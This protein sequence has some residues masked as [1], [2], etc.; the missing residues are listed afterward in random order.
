MNDKQSND[1]AIM[2]TACLLPGAHWTTRPQNR[3]RTDVCPRRIS[4]KPTSS[5]AVSWSFPQPNRSRRRFRS[6]RSSEA[7]WEEDPW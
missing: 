1:I 5:G 4:R 3:A 6:S 2:G 7:L